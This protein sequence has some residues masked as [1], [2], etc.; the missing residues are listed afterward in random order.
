VGVLNGKLS[1]LRWVLGDE[2]TPEFD[3]QQRIAVVHQ[4]KSRRKSPGGST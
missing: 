3:I 2:S 4:T 1:A